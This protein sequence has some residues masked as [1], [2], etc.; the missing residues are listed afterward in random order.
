MVEKKIGLASANSSTTNFSNKL[1]VEIAQSHVAVTIVNGNAVE[2]F[3]F[4]SIEQQSDNW[5]EVLN[6]IKQQSVVL[7][8]PYADAVVYFNNLEALLIPA[9]KFSVESVAPY[10]NS[11]YGEADATIVCTDK[12][13]IANTP[14]CIY[15]VNNHL[16]EAVKNTFLHSR[17]RH[18]FS[19]MLENVLGSETMVMEMLKVQFYAKHMTVLVVYGNKPALIQSYTYNTPEDVVY[20]LLNIVQEYNLNLSSTPVEVSGLLDITSKHFEMLEH[21]FGR[22]SLETVKATGIF[23]NQLTVSNAH[24]YTPFTSLS[25]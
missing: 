6:N 21:L 11:V 13:A 22:L 5:Q 16:Y 4:F 8:Q 3:E 19:K 7:Q 10:L 1:I 24:F 20:Y 17:Y 2:G 12:L 14:V 9:Q 18:S 25:L 23:A 15:R